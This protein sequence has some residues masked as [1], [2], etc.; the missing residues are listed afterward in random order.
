M[1]NTLILANRG[2]LLYSFALHFSL[3][4][5]IIWKNIFALIIYIFCYSSVSY[6]KDRLLLLW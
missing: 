5:L 4:K 1:Q 2:I 3:K 6:Y